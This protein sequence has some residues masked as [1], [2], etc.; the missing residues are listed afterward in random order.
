M[1]IK[2]KVNCF[3]F[4]SSIA[5]YGSIFDD[6]LKVADSKAESS[7]VAED[8][9]PAPEDPYGISKYAF[10]L[11]LKA[12]HE[13]FGIDFVIFRP[14]NV[15]GPHQNMFDKYRNVVGIFINQI[16]HDRPLTVFG[17]GEQTRAFSYISDVAPVIADG[18]LVAKARNEIFNVGADTPYT[19]NV[20]SDEIKDALGKPD[21]PIKKEPARLEVVNAV[22]N[23]DKV[24][25][26][27]G[28][29]EA[30][31]LKDGLAKTITW[32][33][34]QGSMF[35]PVEFESV[36]IIENMPPSW[37]RDDLKQTAICT[38]TRAGIRAASDGS[39]AR[40]KPKFD[41]AEL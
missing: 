12:A 36:E 13:L 35:K 23:H 5:V 33:K 14:H 32:Y 17:D 8:I 7:P 31:S 18:P 28:V 11:D 26:Y 10:E 3:V 27:F 16:F 20:L 15:Y 40:K 1:A 30:V 41:S 39:P 6:Q 2:Y 19:V 37:L 22:S 34:D 29:P 21:H 38:G 25:A 4:T 9:K 24:K